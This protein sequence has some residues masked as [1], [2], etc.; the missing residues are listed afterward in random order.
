MADRVD[1]V[2]QLPQACLHCG[3]TFRSTGHG[4]MCRQCSREV[5]VTT[6]LVRGATPLERPTPARDEAKPTPTP[7]VSWSERGK[8]GAAA[9][10]GKKPD[11]PEGA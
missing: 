10:W 4:V 11:P 8:A 2:K 6:L 9:R 7:K 3:G 1:T 5:I